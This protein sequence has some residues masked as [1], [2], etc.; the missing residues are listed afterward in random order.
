MDYLIVLG[1]EYHI[2][3]V[4]SGKNIPSFF[5]PL[6]PFLIVNHIQ[7]YQGMCP[8]PI[9]MENANVSRGLFRDNWAIYNLLIS[10]LSLNHV[11][12]FLFMSCFTRN[13]CVFFCFGNCPPIRLI[14]TKKSS[15]LGLHTELENTSCGWISSC[16]GRN[17]ILGRQKFFLTLLHFGV[18][19]GG[20]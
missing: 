6:S 7:S 5:N 13:S 12:R 20:N 1:R 11:V 17:F 3:H 16:G 18:I 4:F 14:I 9:S 10:H 8:I 19:F 2:F 15:Y